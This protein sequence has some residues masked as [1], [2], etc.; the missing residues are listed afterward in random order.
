MRLWIDSWIGRRLSPKEHE[1]LAK[2]GLL[3]ADGTLSKGKFDQLPEGTKE[4]IIQA[5]GASN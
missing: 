5:L 1:I 4:Q 3:R 2:H